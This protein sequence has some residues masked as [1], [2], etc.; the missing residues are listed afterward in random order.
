MVLLKDLTAIFMKDSIKLL[1]NI[2]DAIKNKDS[3][4]ISKSAHTIKGAVLSR[5]F[6]SGKFLR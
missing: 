1:N 6:E 3:V 5:F 2:E 4:R